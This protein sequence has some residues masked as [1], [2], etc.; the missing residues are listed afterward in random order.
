M[1]DVYNILAVTHH[2]RYFWT[3]FFSEAFNFSEAFSG[4][5]HMRIHANA[6]G[7]AGPSTYQISEHQTSSFASCGYKPTRSAVH[8]SRLCKSST[9]LTHFLDLESKSKAFRILS[10]RIP[11]VDPATIRGCIFGAGSRSR[12]HTWG[13]CTRNNYSYQ[14]LT[15]MVFRRHVRL[16]I[17]ELTYIASAEEYQREGFASFMLDLM[18]DKWRADDMSYVLTFADVNAVKFF[19]SIGFTD[20]IP[21]PRDLY[22]C[23][24]DKY[25]RSVLMCLPLNKLQECERSTRAPARVEILVF[26]D[27]VDKQAT[28]IWVPGRVIVDSGE[29]AIVQYSFRLKTHVEVLAVDSIRLKLGWSATRSS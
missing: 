25:S 19:E 21:F 9:K 4:P 3:V 20:H 1:E 2:A 6:T 24:I 8:D 28:E 12:Y 7:L 5:R 26:V 13:L 11:S 15:C 10:D 16:G 14:V 22:D 23:W 29:T 27:N 18:M 17:I